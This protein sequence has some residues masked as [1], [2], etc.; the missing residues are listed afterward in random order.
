MGQKTHPS[1]FRLNTTHKHASNWYPKKWGNYAKSLKRDDEIRSLIENELPATSISDIS[2]RQ[3][4]YPK[5]LNVE[6]FVDKPILP[7]KLLESDH[8]DH[9]I[10]D[11]VDTPL[12]LPYSLNLY[13]NNEV[14]S[15]A[16]HLGDSVTHALT[17]RMPF[18]RVLRKTIDIAR[19]SDNIDGVKIQISGR[20]NGAEIA[21]DESIKWGRMP[22][23]TLRAKILYTSR[24]SRTTYG[25]LGVK[26]WVFKGEQF[27]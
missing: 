1:G 8:F 17:H 5:K 24:L 16:V 22:L 15:N 9:Q 20:L 2:I 7:L 10:R 4:Y 26:V 3:D 19:Q 12:T 11:V 21:R 27:K 23:Q 13:T 14:D 6:I 25:V 18:K